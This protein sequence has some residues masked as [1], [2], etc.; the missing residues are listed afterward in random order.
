MI[1]TTFGEVR[2]FDAHTHFL[3]QSFL[4][5]LGQQAGMSTDAAA[6]ARRLEWDVPPADGAEV[7][8]RWVAELEKHGVDRAVGIHTLPGDLE[9]A[10]AGIAAASG[11]LTGYVMINPLAQGAL[12]ML[13]KAVTLGFRGL[14]LFPGLFRFS[15]TS[16]AVYALLQ[17]ANLRRMNVMVHC[18]VLK[19]AFRNKLGLPAA[20]EGTLANPLNLLRPCTEFPQARF[21]VPHLGSGMFRE[22]LMLADQAAN[23]YADTSGIGGWAKYLD[24]GPSK[25][26]VLRQAVN[27]MGAGRL[28]FGTDSTFFPRGWR[29]E[30]FDEHLEVFREAGLND[31]EVRKILGGNLEGLMASAGG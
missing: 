28:L 7:G 6:V 27:V 10:N 11:R 1:Q 5:N 12:A 17:V 30:V 4:A 3:T 24:G 8:R 29:R 23:V 18:G 14:A 15:M 21:V 22:L 19:V 13:E 31:E 25:A 2:V 26:Q 9:Q 20:Y 16:D